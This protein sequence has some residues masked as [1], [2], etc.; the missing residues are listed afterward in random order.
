MSTTN[1]FDI[2]MCNWAKP[3]YLIFYKDRLYNSILHLFESK[4]LR[5]HSDTHIPM[6]TTLCALWLM[7]WPP[8]YST[9][10]VTGWYM[11]FYLHRPEGLERLSSLIWSSWLTAFIATYSEL[12]H[13]QKLKMISFS[14]SC[15]DT[16]RLS[17]HWNLWRSIQLVS[18]YM[19]NLTVTY[20]K[21]LRITSFLLA[22]IYLKTSI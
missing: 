17:L 22:R 16:E 2:I 3:R 10:A 11:S 15:T 21:C 14:S 1:A 6:G 20:Q 19:E 12:L 4:E 18:Q 5:W 13:K 8:W 7:Y 9:K